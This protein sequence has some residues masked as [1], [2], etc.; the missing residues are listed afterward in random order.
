MLSG[1]LLTPSVV[2]CGAEAGPKAPLLLELA[3]DRI[4][5]GTRTV[6]RIRG[7]N[8]PDTVCTLTLSGPNDDPARPAERFGLT[9]VERVSPRLLLAVLPLPL[10]PGSYDLQASCS[11]QA[12]L[13]LPDALLVEDAVQPDPGDG[14]LVWITHPDPSLGVRA[15][16]TIRLEIH[17]QDPCGIETIGYEATGLVEAEEERAVSSGGSE[18]WTSFLLPIPAELRP[19]QLF[20]VVPWAKNGLGQACYSYRATSVIICGDPGGDAEPWPCQD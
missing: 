5:A 15:G 14:P 1:M 17:A 18:A 3:P 20:W 2:G 13:L 6:M 11:G 10:P 19:L 7:E 12:E 4:T 8:L 9:Q 16:S